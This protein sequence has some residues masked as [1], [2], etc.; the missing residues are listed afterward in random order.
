MKQFNIGEHVKYIN[1]RKECTICEVVSNDGD[2]RN[3]FV[4]RI[5]ES[6]IEPDAIGKTF[7]TFSK[8]AFIPIEK[9]NYTQ[10]IDL[11]KN[12]YNV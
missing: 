12:K 4:G 9:D 8:Q 3:S 7:D 6:T 5:I 2:S 1:D 10:L 11:L